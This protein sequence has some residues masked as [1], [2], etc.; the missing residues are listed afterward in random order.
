MDFCSKSEHLAITVMVVIPHG[1]CKQQKLLSDFTAFAGQ[2][3]LSS[4]FFVVSWFNFSSQ[5]I[6]MYVEAP[7]FESPH[8]AFLAIDH[9]VC[10]IQRNKSVLNYL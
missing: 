6:K 3:A 2:T 1:V 4:I 7:S 9:N 8:E 10:F 5:S